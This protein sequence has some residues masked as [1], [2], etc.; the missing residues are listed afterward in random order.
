[1]TQRLDL[2]GFRTQRMALG[3]HEGSAKPLSLVLSLVVVA[4]SF[5]DENKKTGVGG[6][7]C[8]DADVVIRRCL[9]LRLFPC[10]RYVCERSGL[11]LGNVAIDA[12]MVY[13]V[14]GKFLCGCVF[15]SA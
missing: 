7:D 13:R 9:F 8:V 6:R 10:F 12:N 15:V 5:T 2:C 11:L 4:L 14:R 3:F 1:M